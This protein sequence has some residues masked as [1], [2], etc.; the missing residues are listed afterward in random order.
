MI[1]PKQNNQTVVCGICRAKEQF[2]LGELWLKSPN[3]GNHCKSWIGRFDCLTKRR[4]R[5]A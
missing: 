4:E 5:S 3:C 2:I 1:N